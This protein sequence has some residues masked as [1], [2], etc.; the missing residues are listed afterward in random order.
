M[1]SEF[2]PVSFLLR[3][4]FALVL[5]VATY[6][7]TAYSYISWMLSDSFSF[8]PIP[9]LLGLLLLIAWII[10]S[11]ATLLSMGWLGVMLGAAVFI[12][13]IWL[14]IDLGWISVESSGVITWLALLVISLILALGL[15]WSRIRRR[16]TGQVDVDDMDD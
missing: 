12:T 4:L 11:R 10:F 1:A 7:P 3:W 5:V 14:F 16:L 15:S 2:T 6:N 8:G 13:I 9:V